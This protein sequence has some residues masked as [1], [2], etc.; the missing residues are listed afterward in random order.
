MLIQS[1]ITTKQRKKLRSRHPLFR[2]MKPHIFDRLVEI[3]PSILAG[4]V[5]P[6]HYG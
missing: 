4:I 3:M 1:Q 6:D 5:V 2:N